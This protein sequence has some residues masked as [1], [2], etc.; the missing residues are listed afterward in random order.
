MLPPPPPQA[1]ATMTQPVAA[2]LATS[3]PKGFIGVPARRPLLFAGDPLP[4]GNI[5]RSFL[6]SETYYT[7]SWDRYQIFSKFLQAQK[8]LEN[9]F[10][11]SSSQIFP[12][13]QTRMV[14]KSGPSVSQALALILCCNR[15]MYML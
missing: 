1:A 12:P 7:R 14:F 6:N 5:L 15:N 4:F 13:K 2:R 11:S 9:G 3:L 10:S 8:P